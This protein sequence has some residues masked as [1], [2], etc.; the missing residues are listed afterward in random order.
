MLKYFLVL[1]QVQSIG[2]TL[3]WTWIILFVHAGLPLDW[4]TTPWWILNPRLIQKAHPNSIHGL[5]L[6]WNLDWLWIKLWIDSGLNFGLAL[7]YLWIILELVMDWLW[8]HN[9]EII[10][11]RIKDQAIQTKSMDW[12]GIEPRI[13]SGLNFGLTLDYLWIILELLMDWPWIHNP[14]IIHVCRG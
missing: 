4:A 7:D 12:L 1:N 8:I 10:Q 5:T 13:D 3:D 14:E 11:V 2:L 6:D 9:P